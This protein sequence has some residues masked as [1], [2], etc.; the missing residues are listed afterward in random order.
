MNKNCCINY[1][2]YKVTETFTGHVLVWGHKWESNKVKLCLFYSYAL[3]IFSFTLTMLCSSATHSQD[4]T[5]THTHDCTTP[6]A[7]RLGKRSCWSRTDSTC[8]P[9]LG[10]KSTPHQHD[11]PAAGGHICSWLFSWPSHQLQ[12]SRTF[13]QEQQRTWRS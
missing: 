8:E 7:L 4:A 6:S 12:C 9:P 3:Q 1:I 2:S 10:L 13:H 11:A 5:L